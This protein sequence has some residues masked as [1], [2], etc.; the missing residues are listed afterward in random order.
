[1]PPL[2]SSILLYDGVCGLCHGAVRWVAAHDDGHTLRFAPLQGPTAATLR[3][4]R[5]EIPTGLESVVLVEGGQ[6]HLRSQAFLHLARHLRSP[7]RWLYRLRWLPARL[8]DPA[9]RLVAR[10]RYRVFGRHE[11]CEIPSVEDRAR[12]LP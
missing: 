6:V 10:F 8:I 9:Y 4:A 1:M 5:P 11:R 12:L 3:A 2:P 7:W